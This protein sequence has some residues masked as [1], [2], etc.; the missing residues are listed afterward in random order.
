MRRELTTGRRGR[1][2]RIATDGGSE[3]NFVRAP[4]GLSDG[5]FFRPGSGSHLNAMHIHD[6]VLCKTRRPAMRDEPTGLSLSSTTSSI[7]IKL[8]LNMRRFGRNCDYVLTKRGDQVAQTAAWR[9]LPVSPRL[10]PRLSAHG[11]HPR[12]D[13]HQTEVGFVENLK[14]DERVKYVSGT[15]LRRKDAEAHQRQD[16]AMS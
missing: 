9:G 3:L 10:C 4:S 2:C 14:S 13:H 1:F 16:N 5:R 15:F 7:A 12:G 11:A 6:H 8:D